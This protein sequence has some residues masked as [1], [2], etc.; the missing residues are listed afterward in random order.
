M[1]YA[2]QFSGD[3]NAPPATLVIF[4]ASGDLTRRKLIPAVGHLA[5]HG[6]LAEFAVVGVART[7]LDDDAFARTVLGDQAPQPAPQ[8]RGGLRY[9]S[10]GYDDVETYKRLAAVLDELDEHRGTAGNRLYYLSTPPQA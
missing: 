7:P 4:G 2:P 1:D 3:R 10:G 8:L 5:R 9:V 6:R